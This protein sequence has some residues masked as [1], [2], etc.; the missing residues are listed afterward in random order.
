[1]SDHRSGLAALTFACLLSVAASPQGHTPGE[2]L[3]SH[4]TEG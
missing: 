4:D 1:M 3:W 2:V